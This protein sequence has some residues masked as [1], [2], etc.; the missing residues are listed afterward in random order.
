VVDYIG[1]ANELKSALKEYVA[2]GLVHV[3]STRAEAI[4]A[5]I[6]RWVEDGMNVFG[7]PCTVH[8]M[9]IR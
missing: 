6:E 3:H 9:R 7:L 5:L 2:R 8:L 1:I 4:S